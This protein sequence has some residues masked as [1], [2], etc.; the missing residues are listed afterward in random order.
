MAQ[1]SYLF[2]LAAGFLLDRKAQR[3]TNKTVEF[4]RSNLQLFLNWCDLQAIKTIEQLTPEVIRL[5][6]LHL[7]ETKHKAGGVHAK[8]RVIRVFLRWYQAEFEP[9]AWRNPLTKVKPPRVDVEPLEPVPI[10][11][12]RLM[13]D[14]CPRGKFT[15]ERD[16]A[17]ILFLLDTGVRAGE[18]LALDRQD[19]DILTGDVLIRKSKSRK[20]RT[21][22][23]GRQ[24]RRALRVY[25]K[26][27]DDGSRPLF[28]TDERERLKM[29][30]LR[31]IILR[32]ARRAGIPAP[33]MHSFRRAF[34]LAM[35]RA[36]IDLISLQ[37]LMGHADLSQLGRYLAQDAEDLRSDHERGSPA[38]NL[39]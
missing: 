2:T 10:E 15:D 29:P 32:R 34:A 39:L 23:L 17:I 20:A 3:L 8:Y 6:M 38:D 31:Q 21:V 7:D 4:Y 28:V 26:L 19:V 12:V 13:I 18:L 1:D 11:H 36:G 27:R 5:Y 30:G 24:A 37:R 16:R 22:F 14:T 35:K 25:L 33:S 9:A